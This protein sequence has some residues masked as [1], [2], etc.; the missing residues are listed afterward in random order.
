MNALLSRNFIGFYIA[1]SLGAFNDNVYRNA[2]VLLINVAFVDQLGNLTASMAAISAAL[3]MVPFF[4][5]SATAGRLAD[6]MDK[7]RL[8]Q[9]LKWSELGVMMMV[10]LGFWMMQLWLLLGALFLLGIQAA[11]F[12]PVKYSI[13]PQLLPQSSLLA[14]NACVEATTFVVILLGTIVSSVL[15]LD[16][17]TRMD[18]AFACI[19]FSALGVIA[20]HFIHP[21]PALPVQEKWH[22]NIGRDISQSLRSGWRIRTLRYPLIG[23]AWFWGVGTVC[24][25]QIPYYATS[26]L[27]NSAHDLP[28]LLGAF[29]L[30]I[31]LGATICAIWQRGA[32][33]DKSVMI[34]ACLM[35]L[36]ALDFMRT[37]HHLPPDT[38]PIRLAMDLLVLS[39]SAGLIAV[40]LYTLLQHRS[41]ETMRGRTI[42]SSN[43]VNA[44][45]MTALSVVS[46]AAL[47]TGSDVA[48]TM[49][50][51]PLLTLPLLWCAKKQYD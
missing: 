21:Q 26:Q 7:A 18:V 33:N 23:I 15:M 40:P 4:L 5:C 35:A 47:S 25:T 14:G 34:G 11:F 29:T 6:R 41:D 16:A 37:S 45:V 22:W 30:G 1:Q 38:F 44:L 9:W 13:I 31:A 2:L 12:G 42:A 39:A 49:M 46:A 3:F 43:V 27:P 10:A 51:W 19:G 20:S 17:D 24:L 8:V 50:V 32:I 36:A 28:Y 48:L